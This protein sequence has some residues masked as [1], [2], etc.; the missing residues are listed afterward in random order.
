M[1]FIFLLISLFFIN[2][3]ILRSQ[4]RYEDGPPARFFAGGDFKTGQY[5]EKFNS[6]SLTSAYSG[7]INPYGGNISFKGSQAMA[8]NAE[9]GYYFNHNRNIG[10]G[11]GIFYSS[12]KGTASADSFHVEYMNFDYKGHV[13]RQLLSSEGGVNESVKSSN[14][15]IPLFLR[16]KKGIMTDMFISIDGGILFNMM[17]QNK[18][19]GSAA[20]DYEAIYKI[21]GSGTNL[22]YLYD[23]SPYPG[24]TDWLVTKAQFLKNNPNGDFQAYFNSLQKTGFNV[25]LGDTSGKSG[26]IKFTHKSIGFTLQAA[27][28][29]KLR[30][31]IYGKAGF[32]LQEQA[33]SNPSSGSPAPI[34]GQPGDY[35]S[36][37]NYP[38]TIE[39][40]NY[41]FLFGIN[42]Y[43]Y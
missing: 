7:V 10:I 23:N 36:L 17:M 6:A 38:K 24:E 3:S 1:K 9:G 25:G 8:F 5:S 33:F 31:N 42:F 28:N 12:Q 18:Y 16:Y 20:F 21:E 40:W 2:I 43:F 30:D 22:T 34:T 29:Y 26:K 35:N 15:S 27:L 39:I 14:I 37:L 13:F 41:G 19:N 32:Y 11:A 4:I